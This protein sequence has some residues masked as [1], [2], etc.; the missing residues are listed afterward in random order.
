VAY[1]RSVGSG[2]VSRL[3][4]EMQGVSVDGPPG[5]ARQ[6]DD[7][8]EFFILDRGG[9]EETR[10]SRYQRTSAGLPSI[11]DDASA[12]LGSM[13]RLRKKLRKP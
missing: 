11:G 3:L 7:A 2:S 6:A 1:D 9:N 5:E 8:E 4:V 10:R 13:R 12:V